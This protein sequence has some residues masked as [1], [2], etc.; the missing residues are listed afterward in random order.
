MA[1]SSNEI[2]RLVR[3]PVRDTSKMSRFSMHR[4]S[5]SAS[6]FSLKSVATNSSYE[7]YRQEEKLR[8]DAHASGGAWIELFYDLF[9]AAS[10][11]AYSNSREIS[12]HRDLVDLA[13]FFSKILQTARGPL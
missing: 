8:D 2:G 3:L 7:S 10:L 13:A 1:S 6:D 4:T 11:S 9:F 5:T 12:G